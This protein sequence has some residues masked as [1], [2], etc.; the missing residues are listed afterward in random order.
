MLKS[1]RIDNY[2]INSLQNADYS[3]QIFD[4]NY[5]ILMSIDSVSESKKGVDHSGVNRYY[6]KPLN[7]NG[8]LY[9]LTSQWYERN[10]V[11]LIQWMTKFL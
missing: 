5:P 8:K 4:I 3:K 11:K 1:G 7:L 10:K 9:L 2:I 6:A